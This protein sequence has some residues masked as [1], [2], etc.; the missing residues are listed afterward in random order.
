MPITKLSKYI[1]SPNNYLLLIGAIFFLIAAVV[2][3]K[4]ERPVIQLSK[5][6]TALN[7][8]KDLL[9]FMSA[10]NKRLLTDLLWVQ[11]LIE[12]DLEQYSGKDLN[13][14][15]FLRF[16]TI[17]VLDPQFYENYLYGG[18]FLN[19][20]KND[21]LGADILYDKALTVYPDD[22]QLN[23]FAGVMNYF[24]IGNNEKGYKYLK[25]IQHHP[26]APVFIQ[27]IVNKL[28]LA[29]GASLEDIF[30]LVLHHYESTKDEALK[31]KLRA[32][33]YAIK[34][35]IDL[36]CLKNKNSNCDKKD[37]DGNFYLKD[38]NSYRALKSFL[39]Y[40]INIRR[41]DKSPLPREE[42]NSFN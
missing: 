42:I 31:N 18:Q 25:K 17:S 38:N 7:I 27:S 10:G 37:L 41:G 13:N 14:W 19:V 33:L 1:F 4:L 32:D 6:D 2:N 9:I 30:Q 16:N 35:E 20:V 39:P 26:N 5:Q 40:R 12:T 3:L 28:F 15:L 21:L 29:H 8:N 22:Y 34:A 11:T 24:E 36:K 23:Y